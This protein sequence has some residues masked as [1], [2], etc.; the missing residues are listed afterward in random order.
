M[1]RPDKGAEELDRILSRMTTTLAHRGPDDNGLW[2]DQAAGVGL[3]HRRLSIQDLSPLG[4]QPMVSPSGR[5]V[6]VYNGEVYN[7]EEIRRAL[8]DQAI[9]W[10]GHSDT[11]VILA[12][13][14]TWG[15]ETALQ[16]FVGMFAF[17]LWDSQSQTLHLARD[18]LGIKPLYYGWSGDTLLFGS[19]LKALRAW[20]GFSN[21]V[22]RAALALYLRHDY[23][24]G[25]YAI[26]ENVHKLQPGHIIS[27]KACAPAKASTKAYWSARAAAAAGMENP[28]MGSPDEAVLGLE[29]LLGEAVGMRMVADVPLG[30]FLSGGID[31]SVVTAL[32]QARSAR[33]V[34]TFSIGFTESEYNEAEHAKTVARHLG[35][36][37]TELYVTPEQAMA[38]I[39]ALPQ[40]Y[41]EPLAA[42]SQIP[43]YLL[44]QLAHQ[45][46][47]VALSGDGGDELFG[48]YNRYLWADAVWRRAKP[49]PLAVRRVAAN[50]MQALSPAVW[51][52]IYAIAAT[53][54][55]ARYRA[56]LPGEKI[57]KLSTML[58]ADGPDD[59]Y[60]RL[61]SHWQ[62]PGELLGGEF[63]PAYVL[64]EPGLEQSFPNF[65]QR[66]M[67]L[68]MVSY[69]PDEVLDKVDRAT[70]GSGLEA[71]VPLLDHRVVEFAWRLPLHMKIRNGQGK[72]PLREVLYKYVPRDIIERPKAGFTVPIGDW[73]R[74]PLREWA[75]DL[76]TS[77]RIEAQGHFNAH[78]LRQLWSEHLSGKRNWQHQLWNVLVFNAWSESQSR[79]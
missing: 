25:P 27:I 34:R 30:A 39:P 65:V 59:V 64:T 5:Y 36:D 79:Q 76:L 72:W 74:G 19:E 43:L 53:A 67:Y 42:P 44:S 28:F 1:T 75:E 77:E 78:T 16:R 70:M 60:R 40:L 58:A 4:H 71:R 46:V 7:F 63:E 21:R 26:Y 12:A 2:L 56:S 31:S 55:P 69:L 20:P 66:M 32:M 14:E 41:D 61:V 23:V 68:D 50:A 52:R 35:T 9:T 11:E 37:H 51:N 73:L 15:L 6:I 3:G 45:H 18:R 54:L 10:R 62:Q 47:T 57:Y 48:G 49:L 13:I 24:P 17:A 29:A 22:D 33:P 8:C 38:V